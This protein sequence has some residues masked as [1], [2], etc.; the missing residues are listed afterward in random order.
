M[1]ELTDDLI[2]DIFYDS[3]NIPIGIFSSDGALNKLYADLD[4]ERTKIF[5]E[6]SGILLSSEA[7]NPSPVLR[8]D[9]KGSCWCR[10]PLGRETLLFGP[11]QTGRNPDYPY[12]GVPEHTWNGF[13]EI[14]RCLISMLSGKETGLIEKEE[15]YTAAHTARRMLEAEGKK[16][17]WNSFDEMFDCVRQGDLKQ[18]ETI[19]G[20][21]E[22]TEYLNQVMSD[23]QAARNVF[24]F[25]L[26]KT[27]HSAISASLALQDLAPLVSLYLSEEQKYRS[28]AA[29]KAGMKRSMFDFTRYVSKYHDG[30]HSHLINKARLYIDENLY[31]EIKLKEIA[32]HCGV[33][34][35]TLQHR[36]KEEMGISVSDRIRDRKI[37]RACF[38]LKHTNIPC[39]DIAF[40]IGYES[41]SYFNKQF[42]KVTGVTPQEYRSGNCT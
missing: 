41:Q 31:S 34:V 12:E 14:S 6:D 28:I 20:S 40:K 30:R 29:Y 35:S 7:G 22:Y 24:H 19:L 5:L 23:L 33:S 38:F 25:N 39:G 37:G 9:P 8:F 16:N 10:I 13:R 3:W 32:D 17:E 4:T 2:F 15:S 1:I 18:L 21:K 11:V 27:Y 36:F 26:A 42:K